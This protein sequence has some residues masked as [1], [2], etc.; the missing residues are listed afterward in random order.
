MFSGSNLT[1]Q[2]SSFQVSRFKK[3]VGVKSNHKRVKLG[4][5]I[6]CRGKD[7]IVGVE[8]K[9]FLQRVTVTA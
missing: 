5:I 4:K 2:V 9:K 1:Y 3:I 8:K 6:I 7:I